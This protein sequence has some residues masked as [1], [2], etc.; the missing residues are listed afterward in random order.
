MNHGQD[1]EKIWLNRDNQKLFY[2]KLINDYGMK[3]TILWVT[4]KKMKKGINE[5][6]IWRWTG[7][8]RSNGTNKEDEIG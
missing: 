7:K 3:E 4:Q 5:R 2:G 6:I 1:L 8:R